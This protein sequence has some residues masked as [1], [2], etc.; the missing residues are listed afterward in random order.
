[1]TKTFKVERNGKQTWVVIRQMAHVIPESLS[2]LCTE[3]RGKVVEEQ[4]STCQFAVGDR[5]TLLVR[6]R[7]NATFAGSRLFGEKTSIVQ[8]VV[9]KQ[10]TKV[11]STHEG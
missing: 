9:T 11:G 7:I 10:I 1:M 8:G 2:L 6:V 3:D 4:S 5:V